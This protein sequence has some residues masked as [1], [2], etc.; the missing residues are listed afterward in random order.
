MKKPIKKEKVVKKP[1]EDSKT[2]V[3]YVRYLLED[4]EAVTELIPTDEKEELKG[5]A[6]ESILVAVKK[7]HVRA[8]SI[9]KL[10]K[11]KYKAARFDKIEEVSNSI[12]KKGKENPRFRY[13]FLLKE[14]TNCR[15]EISRTIEGKR[16]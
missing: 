2:D 6:L 15:Q 12:L 13:A 4:M 3:I 10:F 1:K 16:Y 14:F 7:V 9:S 5:V 11:Q 8:K